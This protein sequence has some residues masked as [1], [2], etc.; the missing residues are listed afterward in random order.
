M[1]LYASCD[2]LVVED[3]AGTRRAMELLLRQHGHRPVGFGSA[4]EALAAVSA[5]CHP[6]VALVDFDLP[7]MN[8]VE[9]IFHMRA[10]LPEL[11]PVLITAAGPDRV[12][13]ADM[14]NATYFRK[15][16]RFD[17]LLDVVDDVPS[18]PS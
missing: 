4:E 13:A 18:E 1:E 11:R 10:M 15:P 8:G 3:E 5:G 12:A 6:C 14:R 2:V 7:G 9:L 17:R 16:I